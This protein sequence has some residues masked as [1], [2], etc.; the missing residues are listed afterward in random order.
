MQ[1]LRFALRMLRK[2]PVFTAVAVVTLALGIG[3]NTAIF[4][5]VYQILLRPLPYGHA[6]R[7]VF[8]WNSYPGSNLPQASV[9]IPDYLD[10]KTQAPALEDAT[11]FTLRAVNLDESGT[12]EQIRAL[13]VTPSFFSTLGRT[14]FL[15]RAFAEA[16][17]TP[18]ADRFVILTYAVWTS[19]YGADL[20]VVGRDA[21]IDGES[22][23][24]VGVLPADV[25]LPSRD[26]ALLVPFSF[27]PAQMSDRERGNEYSSMIAR[28]RPG[29]T[30]A[31]ANAQF[32][33]IIARNLDRMPE[34]RSFVQTSGFNAYAIGIRDQLVGDVRTPLYV[35]QAGVVLVLLMA[36]A[37]VANLLMMRATG[38]LRELAIRGAL[39]ATRQRVLVQ[40]LTEGLVLAAAGA[41]A[42]L[43]VGVVGLRAL[44]GLGA[45]QIPG[46]P[47]ATLHAPVLLFAM[48][49]AAV[50]GVV[51]GLAPAFSVVHGEAA[52]FLRDDSTRG[53]A[54]RAAGAT[55]STLVVLEMAFAVVLLVGAGLTIK[56]VDR[57]QRVDPGFS[58][59]NVLTAQIALTGPRYGNNAVRAAFWHEVI[60]R[61]RAIPGVTSAGLT[62]NIPFN[63][64]VDSGS[65]SIEGR[66][67]AP[68]EAEPHSR[69][70]AVG[71]EYF[72]ALRIPL[73]SG[74]VFSDADTQGAPLVCVIDQYLATKYFPGRSPLG[75]RITNGQTFTIVGVVGSIN[76]VDLG[77][78]V[79]KERIYFAVE[80]RPINEMGVV[81][82]T[83][84]DPTRLVGPLRA[85]VKAID[86]EQGIADVRTLDQWVARSLDTR[87]TP[88]ALLAV[89]GALALTLAAVGIYGVIAFGV[90]Q[91]AR[92]FGI[93]HA[94][95]ADSASILTL[96]VS[97]GLR[98]AAAGIAIGVVGAFAATRVLQS[99]LFGVTSHDPIVFGGVAIGL[100]GVAGAASYVPAR[101]ATRVDPMV[102]LRDS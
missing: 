58:T 49:L 2:Q 21:R 96:V 53:T 42:G 12:P 43:V 38:R 77:Q 46:S 68:G 14:P 72:K 91:R 93:R 33:T 66:T 3:A 50:T 73:V 79:T 69:Q 75:E 65:Y 37:N 45:A 16:D 25:D 17:A 23:R 28:L 84:I 6:D 52:A 24:V 26:V 19:R 29:A 88:M 92:E 10:R 78:P 36:C 81:L 30:L 8:V 87:R 60:D 39:G 100:L 61:L 63:G 101:R 34:R 27:T 41:A 90:A 7:L 102:V 35:L 76:S 15:G 44:I 4:S 89:F 40:L 82:K 98:I 85:A 64:M 70:E 71:G 80:Q 95:G 51:F 48:A 59:D 11:L 47:Q 86:A 22:Y 5:L 1:N 57:L 31:E 62:S 94:L 56:S 99:L 67:L 54:G 83:A 32:N 18:G 9:S 74:R 55:R 20:S 97:N 13:A